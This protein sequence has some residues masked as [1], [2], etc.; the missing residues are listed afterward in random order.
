MIRQKGG[1]KKNDKASYILPP[2]GG[3]QE[4]DRAEDRV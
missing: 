3:A 1:M 2:R 4:G